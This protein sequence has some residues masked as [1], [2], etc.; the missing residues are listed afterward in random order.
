[1]HVTGDEAQL[2]PNEHR[3]DERRVMKLLIALVAAIGAVA[4]A[5]FFARKNAF[6]RTAAEK[7]GD[8]TDKLAEKGREA[9]GEVAA[10]VK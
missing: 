9:A 1:M 10:A 3:G 7:A 6:Y 8:A 4:V 5:V 2:S